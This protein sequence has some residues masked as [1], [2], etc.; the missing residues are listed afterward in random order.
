M[1]AQRDTAL[2]WLR[3]SNGQLKCIQEGC[4]AERAPLKLTATQLWHAEHN[5]A[6]LPTSAHLLMITYV[7]M[8]LRTRVDW[9]LC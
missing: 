2:E 6:R 9:L 8:P 4:K 1:T 7:L 5:M 3:E